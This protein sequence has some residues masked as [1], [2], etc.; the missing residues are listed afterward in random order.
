MIWEHYSGLRTPR[1]RPKVKNHRPKSNV[2]YV[3]N[4]ISRSL[5]PY[6]VFWEAKGS[7]KRVHAKNSRINFVPVFR[8]KLIR[9]LI[10]ADLVLQPW[11]VQTFF[12]RKY[13]ILL[14]F[15][16]LKAPIEDSILCHKPDFIHHFLTRRAFACLIRWKRIQ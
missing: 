13:L 9:I 4:Q 14:H 12:L 2:R 3:E 6:M 7:F 5:W 16:I 11:W 15:L 1:S 8:I 10:S